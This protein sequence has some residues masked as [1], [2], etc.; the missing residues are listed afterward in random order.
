M[1]IADLMLGEPQ[2]TQNEIAKRLNY[3]FPWLSLI[4]NTDMFKAYFAS[5]REAFN[6]ALSERISGK[7]SQATEAALDNLIEGINSK[8][9][10]MSVLERKEVAD[11]L[12]Q[13][14]GY[15][16][17]TA[18]TIVNNVQAVTSVSVDKDVLIEARRSL[19]AVE[20][21][22]IAQSRGELIEAQAESAPP[23]DPPPPAENSIGESSVLS[24]NVE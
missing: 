2:L 8:G 19:R 22:R 3:S 6:S 14:L 12:L 13:R 9:A 1:A 15:G 24:L 20:E 17:K 23:S 5:R 21:L 7:L 4:V 18:P 11:T 10:N 16:M